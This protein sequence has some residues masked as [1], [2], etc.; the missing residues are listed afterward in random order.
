MNLVLELKNGDEKLL[1][2]L[3]NI[4]SLYHNAKLRVKKKEEKK[5]LTINGYTKEFEE[6]VVEEL[7]EL[8]KDYARGKVQACSVSEFRRAIDNGEI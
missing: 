2:V 3:K 1:K 4:V 5:N 6:S 8:K 7:R